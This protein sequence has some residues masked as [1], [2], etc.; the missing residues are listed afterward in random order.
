ML[1]MTRSKPEATAAPLF[2]FSLRKPLAFAAGE[3]LLDIRLSLP[4]GQWLALQG[5]SGA[6]KTT[7]LRLLAGLDTP[8][9]GSIRLGDEIWLDTA[10]GRQL[11][12]S[13]RRIGLVFQEHALFPHMNARRQI[14]F[15]RRPDQPAPPTDELLALVGLE[16]LAER[17][18]SALSGGQKQRLA[19]A[20]TLA[21]SPRVLLLDE[22]LSALDPELRRAMQ[23]LL[24]RIRQAGLVDCAILV[25]HDLAEA[26]QLADR[27]VR[28]QRGRIHADRPASSFT[29]NSPT[30]VLKES[31]CF[32][33][34]A[35]F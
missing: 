14:D 7:L 2:S 4:A 34:A 10:M 18:P 28:L 1:A 30:P 11:P 23:A 5:P 13:R 20:R 9:D 32:S 3:S 31:S 27:I 19:L 17:Y 35:C 15:A 6:G 26:H 29:L 22:P 33:P 16:Q 25:T 21:S 12:T 8:A 24:Q